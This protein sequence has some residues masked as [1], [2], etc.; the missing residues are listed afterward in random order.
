MYVQVPSLWYSEFD[1]EPEDEPRVRICNTGGRLELEVRLSR[2]DQS[3]VTNG[4]LASRK[5][6]AQFA[7]PVVRISVLGLQPPCRVI[8]TGSSPTN[9]TLITTCVRTCAEKPVCT[10]PET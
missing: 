8:E 9:R 6:C 10:G 4:Y 3:D 1:N 5:V 7:R 2:L